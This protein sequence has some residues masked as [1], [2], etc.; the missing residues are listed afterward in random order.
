M[1]REKLIMFFPSDPPARQHHNAHW[2]GLRMSDHEIPARDLIP[3]GN[4]SS[5]PYNK[6]EYLA[7]GCSVG[8]D[9]FETLKP[10][11]LL[12]TRPFPRIAKEQ[13]LTDTTEVGRTAF[14]E[15][16]KGKMRA[17]RSRKGARRGSRRDS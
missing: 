1:H 9:C 2:K 8:L 4:W 17:R 7:K 12:F 13:G 16:Q 5:S 10:N 6:S 15:S 3:V 14:L 11:D